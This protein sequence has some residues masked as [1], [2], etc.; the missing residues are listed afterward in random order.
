M[1][2]FVLLLLGA[3]VFLG[4]SET[5]TDADAEIELDADAGTLEL[6]TDIDVDADVDMDVD[7]DA[8]L[9]LDA[10]VDTEIG[11]EASP[12]GSFDIEADIH[13][14]ADVHAELDTDING[15]T[16]GDL[17]PAHVNAHS[18]SN[19]NTEHIIQATKKEGG[20]YRKRHIAIVLAISFLEYLNAGKVPLSIVISSWLALWAFFG[21]MIN[22]TLVVFLGGLNLFSIP[23]IGGLIFGSVFLASS[24]TALPL[25]RS[26]SKTFGN[27][28]DTKNYTSAK[29]DYIGSIAKVVSHKVP[30]YEE[31]K[32]NNAIGI[33]EYT[34]RFGNRQKLYAFTPDS[35]KTEPK[36]NDKVI[37]TDYKEE[38][39]LYEVLVEDSDD[40]LAW[41]N[42][43]YTPK[44]RKQT[45]TTSQSKK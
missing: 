45:T 24:L 12:H 11:L 3:T 13:A 44:K 27:V 34:D 15:D 37:I 33:L 6:D 39:R 14:D 43:N 22:T 38:K 9:D 7:A 10:G 1:L 5:D 20:H 19:A 31:V 16:T 40:H 36:Y 21:L 35:C 17:G 2:L 42:V 26:T 32:N 25:V 4:G 18:I 23:V 29:T 41:E 28:F 30:S 8:D